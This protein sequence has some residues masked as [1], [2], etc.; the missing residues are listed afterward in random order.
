MTDYTK[1]DSEMTRMEKANDNVVKRLAKLIE[2]HA[3]GAHG[4][5]GR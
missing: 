1:L 5:E 2:R 4:S 3:R